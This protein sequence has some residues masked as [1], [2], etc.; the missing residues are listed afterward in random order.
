VNQYLN[1]VDC[2]ARLVALDNEHFHTAIEAG[3]FDFAFIPSSL[4]AWANYAHGARA[5][6]TVMRNF[7]GAITDREGGVLF[8][9]ADTHPGILTVQVREPWPTYC[10]SEQ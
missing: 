7:Q 10:I 6:A 2:H 3:A 5:L 8:R 4:Y 9:R 1:H